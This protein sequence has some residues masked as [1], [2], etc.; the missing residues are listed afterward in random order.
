MSLTDP[1]AD[2]FTCIRNAIK[3]H[4]DKVDI[5][6]SRMKESI[7]NVLKKEGYIRDFKILPDN[8]QN[9]LRVQLKYLD[10]KSSAI[11]NIKRVSKPSRRIYVQKTGIQ[12]VRRY[13]GIAVLSTTAGIL[14][15]REARKRG[16][17]GEIICEVW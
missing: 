5:P 1:L 6:S 13:T 2:M 11:E 15:D 3:S 14:T 7:A 4:F 17:G 9:I 12:P 16:V 10:D 8:K